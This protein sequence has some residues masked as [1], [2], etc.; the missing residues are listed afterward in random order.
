MCD[1]V[2]GPPE[3]AMD[4]KTRAALAILS[5]RN[6]F[7]LLEERALRARAFVHDI[8]LVFTPLFRDRDDYIAEMQVLY[9]D[10]EELP[11]GGGWELVENNASGKKANVNKVWSRL[12]TK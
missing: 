2:T 4:A 6:A 11:E 12:P 5:M 3:N 7:K 1:H 9:G 10:S 8:F